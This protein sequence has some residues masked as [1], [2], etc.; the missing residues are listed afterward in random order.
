MKR[1]GEEILEKMA[2]IEECEQ[3][4]EKAFPEW[5]QTSMKKSEFCWQVIRDATA[6]RRSPIAATSIL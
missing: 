2:H 4:I 5:N 6:V 1:P 3:K